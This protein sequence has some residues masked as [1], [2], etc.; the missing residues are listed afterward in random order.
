M[1]GKVVISFFQALRP[2]Q[3]IENVLIFVALV[4]SKN[5]LHPAMLLKTVA[6]F[7][8][9]CMLSGAVYVLNDIL[10][11]ESDRRHPSKRNRPLASGRLPMWAALAGAVLLP[12]AALPL[13]LVLSPAFGAVSLV[14]YCLFLAYSLGAKRVVIIDV[15]IVSLAYVLRAIAGAELI[16][17]PI[18]SWLLLC[19][20]FLAL[21]VTLGK[22]RHELVLLGEGSAS[23]RR[24]LQDYSLQFLDQMIA[25]A[26]A[27]SVITYALYT[28]CEET[29]AKFGT[30]NLLLTLPFVV[31]GIFRYTYLVHI[32][33][34]GGSPEQIFI[35]DL[36]MMGNLVL[37]GV[38]VVVVLYLR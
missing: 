30:R 15:I 10:D 32:R 25:V 13:G 6:G 11:L 19:T 35:S 31:Y 17:V 38:A 8:L 2:K 28:V 36:P 14:Y 1:V 27:S 12:G 20:T 24:S 37:W 33:N 22:R 26:T 29:V 34:L 23:H 4:F 21:F 16:G 7:G 18:S 5:L 9:F 3:W